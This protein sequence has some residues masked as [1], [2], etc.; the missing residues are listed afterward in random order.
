MDPL[1]ITLARFERGYLDP[2]SVTELRRREQLRILRRF[3]SMLNGPIESMTPEDIR[4]FVG[5]EVARGVHVNTAAK[6]QNMIRAFITWAEGADLIA[7]ELA[8]KLKSVR[9]PR[10][11]T[12]RTR[13]K[14]YKP[15]QIRQFYAVLGAKYPR[16]AEFGTGSRALT[17]Y[18]RGRHTRLHSHLWRHTRRLQFEAQ[19]ALALEQ[20]LRRKEINE[21]T[22]PALHPDN[23]EVVVLTAKQAPGL[24]IRRS[25]PYTEHA[26]RV[27]GDWLRLR[28]QLAPNHEYPWLTLDYPRSYIDGALADQL[29]AQNIQA[30]EEAL[31]VFGPGWR[32]HRFRHTAAT[33]WLRAGVPLE[34]VRVFMGHGNIEQT[35][36]YAEIL[37]A[38]IHNEFSRAEEGFMRRLGLDGNGEMAA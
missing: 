27:V 16:L 30:M 31:T 33:E 20:G 17:Q 5:A 38:D 23:A 11:A 6:Y 8:T 35:L 3:A 4:T 28:K 15:D 37:K 18:T 22:I 24:E 13:P 14:P 19:I 34:K 29:R 26:R 9:K 2:N 12:Y 36:A 7:P 25:I 10:G 1:D 32:W 21:L